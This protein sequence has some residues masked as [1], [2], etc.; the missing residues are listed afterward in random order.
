MQNIESK[1]LSNVKIASLLHE[2][3]LKWYQHS[4]GKF[5]LEGDSNICYF[6]SVA[7][8]RRRKKRIHTLVQD[9]GTIEGLDNLKNYITNYYMNLFGAPEEGTFLVDESQIEDIPQVSIEENNLL[10]TKYLE[11]EVRKA[12]FQMEHNNALGPDGLPAEFN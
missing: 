1:K 2:E 6:H 9:E 12:I 8:G 7:N 5:I 11:E 3:E 4:K 10:T